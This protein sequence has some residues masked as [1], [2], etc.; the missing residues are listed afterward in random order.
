MTD[1][2]FSAHCSAKAGNSSFK[3]ERA[4]LLRVSPFIFPRGGTVHTYGRTV[5]GIGILCI[6]VRSDQRTKSDGYDK[7]PYEYFVNARFVRCLYCIPLSCS[8]SNVD[9]HHRT[10]LTLARQRIRDLISPLPMQYA[11]KST[12]KAFQ[13]ICSRH[14]VL[15]S[16]V[17]SHPTHSC[18]GTRL[19]T[20][21]ESSNSR[22]KPD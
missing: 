15:Y 13:T 1:Q 8:S 4:G 11:Y 17:R 7:T 22:K 16:T 9:E 3:K 5:E 19:I 10:I 21:H 18:T 6:V 2:W 14:Q 20:H 12:M